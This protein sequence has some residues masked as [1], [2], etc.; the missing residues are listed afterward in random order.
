[1]SEDKVR[2]LYVCGGR[3]FRSGNPPRKIEKVVDCWRRK[4]YEILHVCGADLGSGVG[5]MTTEYGAQEHHDRWYRGVRIGR[6]LVTTLSEWR[7]VCHDAALVTDLRDRCA[8]WTPDL[9][10]E[11][12]SRLHCAGMILARE[13]RV[14]YVLEWK[15]HLVDYQFSLFRRKALRLEKRKI[16]D[17]DFVV[18][19]SGVLKHQLA[20]EGADPGRTIVAHNAVDPTEF[21]RD[22]AARTAVRREIEVVDDAV[23][24]GYLGS[25]AFYHDA[26]RLVL[27]ADL[28]RSRLGSRR[29]RFLMVGAGKEYRECRKLAEKTGLIDG[30]LTMMPGV[31]KGEV[32]GILAALDIAI[33]PGSTDIIC[34]IKIQEY[35][36]CGLP[37][38]APDYPCNREVI[39]NQRTGVLFEPRNEAALSAAI[40][41]LADDARKREMIGCEARQEIE[42]RFTWG[43]TWGAALEFVVEKGV[44]T[45]PK[46]ERA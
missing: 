24:V 15:D 19:E 37:T 35:M 42:D 43:K 1:M 40:C 41:E 36:A 10:W 2:V 39:D 44:E 4:G 3:S 45:R 25:Y 23:L 11:R 7:D 12:S 26:R 5:G 27:A 30:A 46:L 38:V 21:T 33:L 8:G 22:S 13:L 9:I 28:V 32:P 18:V 31:P 20:N 6:P 14:P 16:S 17:A 29:V 34:P